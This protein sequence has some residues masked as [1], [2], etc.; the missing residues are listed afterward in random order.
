MGSEIEKM[1]FDKKE[2]VPPCQEG[3]RGRNAGLGLATATSTSAQQLAGKG[4]ED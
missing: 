4:I 1:S 2:V 3:F